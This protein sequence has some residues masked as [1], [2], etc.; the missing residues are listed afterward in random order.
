[1]IVLIMGLPGAGKTTLAKYLAKQLNAVHWNA[2]SVRAAFGTSDKFY[3]D[4]RREQAKRMLFLCK[5]VSAAGHVAI[6]D[7]I[8]PLPDSQELFKDA[9]VVF[10]DRITESRYPDTD[11]IFVRPFRVDFHYTVD[12]TPEQVLEVITELV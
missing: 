9:F 5:T 4:A 3:L 12:S 8:C 7:F 11:S 6:A 10:V 1:M 2:D